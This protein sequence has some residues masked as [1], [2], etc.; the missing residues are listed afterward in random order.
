MPSVCFQQPDALYNSYQERPQ[1]QTLKMDSDWDSYLFDE[2]VNNF[3]L[4]GEMGNA[5]L[6]I[7]NT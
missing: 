2:Y 6:V 1:K 4:L 5:T 3:F 7:D